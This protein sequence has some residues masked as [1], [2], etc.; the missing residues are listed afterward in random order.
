MTARKLH[1]GRLLRPNR[2]GIDTQIQKTRIAA[3]AEALVKGVSIF[4]RLIF[5]PVR[6]QRQIELPRK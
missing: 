5:S 2:L 3:R 6:F 1:T 4:F